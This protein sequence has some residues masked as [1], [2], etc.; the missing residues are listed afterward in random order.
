MVPV[1]Y[2]LARSLQPRD[3][4]HSMDNEDANG[5]TKVEIQRDIRCRTSSKLSIRIEL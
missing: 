3:K 4:M 1:L 2:R 5:I